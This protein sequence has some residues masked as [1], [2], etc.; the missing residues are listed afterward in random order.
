MRWMGL[1]TYVV[2]RGDVFCM[3]ARESAEEVRAVLC[4]DRVSGR[5]VV[6][7]MCYVAI[8]LPSFFD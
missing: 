1:L 2:L 8:L 6:A 5:P 3:Q 7:L 4:I